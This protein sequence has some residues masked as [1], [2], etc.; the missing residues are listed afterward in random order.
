MILS[1][2]KS[3]K[4]LAGLAVLSIA[5]LIVVAYL[6]LSQ[7]EW[8]PSADEMITLRSL[9]IGSLQALPPDPSNK[10]ADDPR[11][12][13]FG[14]RLFIDE[15]FSANGKV[16]CATCH[17][18]DL[19][20]QD[21]IPLAKGVGTTNRRTMTLVGTAYSPWLFWD[22]RKDSQWAQALGPMESTVEHGG[23]RTFYAHLI[24]QYYRTDYESLFGPLPD[25]LRF[26]RNA[27]PIDDPAARAAWDTT[28]LEDRQVISRIYANMG[29]AIAAYERHL[30]PGPSRFDSYVEAALNDDRQKMQTLLTK[31]EVA[32]LRLFI[33]KA[34]CTQCHN[35]PLLTDNHFHN[36]GVP[37]VAT[38]PEDRGRA[39]GAPQ[40]Q[41]DEFNCLSRYSD[42]KSEDC[43]ELRYMVAD[44]HDLLRQFKPPSL[45]NVDGRGPF[46]HAGQFAT[47]NDVVGHYNRAPEAPAGHSEIHPLNLSDI[48]IQQLIAFL[49]TL[50]GPINTELK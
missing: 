28:S 7:A 37:A 29:K 22:G 45:R 31:D 36:T 11:A 48:E 18:P 33:G 16:S 32:G 26:P 5:S 2:L 41:T 25:L 4:I 15:R 46:M 21:G 30:Q 20:F 10:Y 9:W 44:G 49:K 35:G 8:T 24:V 13:V 38:L 14:Q 42:A 50:N 6:I 12:A 43:A 47:L 19:M 27:G 17:K 1:S 3:R 23:N 39:Q 34:N 40:V